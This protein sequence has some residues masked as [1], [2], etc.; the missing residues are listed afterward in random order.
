MSPKVRILSKHLQL[1]NKKIGNLIGYG[2]YRFDYLK[3]PEVDVFRRKMVLYVDVESVVFD[4]LRFFLSLSLVLTHIHT[5]RLL[6]YLPQLIR[7]RQD[8]TRYRDPFEYTF[9]P[10]IDT[11]AVTDYLREKIG[12]SGR[13][14]IRLHLTF[15]DVVKTI[16]CQ[17]M[18]GFAIACSDLLQDSDT[19]MKILANFIPKSKILLSETAVPENYCLKVCGS[20]DYLTGNYPLTSFSYIR[21]CILKD[22]KI[23][24]NLVVLKD[25]ALPSNELLEEVSF[26]GTLST[27]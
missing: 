12:P 23:N 7:V 13:L 18:Y 1:V 9:Q 26:H 16:S 17:G 25:V 5:H 15:A 19:P 14:T 24:L 10:D 4:P 3:D 8:A 6:S 21:K 20:A 22:E 11:S 27:K 2:L